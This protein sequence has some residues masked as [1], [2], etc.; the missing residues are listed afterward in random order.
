MKYESILNANFNF[1]SALNAN[2]NF[3]IIFIKSHKSESKINDNL[4]VDSIVNQF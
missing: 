2:F 3:D 1:E 4:N